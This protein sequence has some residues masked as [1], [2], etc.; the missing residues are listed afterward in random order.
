MTKKQSTGPQF[1]QFT[2]AASLINKHCVNN[3]GL[4]E[5]HATDS[6][7][8]DA[9][10]YISFHKPT[11]IIVSRH[12]PGYRI[13]DLSGVG[14]DEALGLLLSTALDSEQALEEFRV[15]LSSPS[16]STSII[17]ALLPRAGTIVRRG[18]YLISERQV[19]EATERVLA[20]TASS[21]NANVVTAIA[22]VHI[23]VLDAMGVVLMGPERKHSVKADS[24]ALN[25]SHIKDV[26]LKESLRDVFSEARIA[27]AIRKLTNEST[28]AIIAEVISQMLRQAAHAIPEIR[29]R[30]EQLDIVQSLIQTYYSTPEK[31]SNTMRASSALLSLAGYANFLA[32]VVVNKKVK[33]PSSSNSDMKEACSSILTLIQAAPSIE[34]MSLSKYAEFVGFVPCSSSEGIYRG[35]VG[36]M[37]L[38]QTSVLDLVNES[39]IGSHGSESELALLPREYVPCTALAGDISVHLTSTDSF[40]GLANIVAD[41]ISNSKWSLEDA[42][43]LRTIGLDEYTLVYLAM[44][45]AEVTAVV[46]SDSKTAP[47][48]LIYATTVKEHWRTRLAASTPNIAYFGDA[49]SIIIYQMGANTVLPTPLPTRRQS[50]ELSAAY[51]TRYQGVVNKFLSREIEKPYSFALTVQLPGDKKETAELKPRFVPLEMLVGSNPSLQRG[52]AHYALVTEPG[53][54]RDTHITLGLAAAYASEGDKIMQDKAKSWLVESLTPLATHPA[55]TRIAVKALNKAVI[56]E[57]LD[58][59]KLAMT[60]KNVVVNAYFATAMGLLHR[61][62]KV[63]DDIKELIVEHMPI[64]TLEVKAAITLATIPTA[65][66][67]SSLADD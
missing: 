8:L 27:D 31:L 62:D 36:Y 6:M 1:N 46:K 10:E 49:Q 33:I 58:A 60:Y 7:L 11:E 24:M 14:S 44:A 20:Q 17:T 61:F 35:V 12:F 29:L 52:G 50:L 53:V 21:V 66:D 18:K 39:P 57:K 15:I 25:M 48:R 42:P 67:A 41:E 26:I 3:D 56:D 45:K 28:P 9:S 22:A 55:V 51:D 54:N 16:Y 65:V 37:P 40:E 32:D 64:S 5:F 23:K 34:I 63:D 4:K 43:V 2:K 19:T 47:F 13:Y 30:L 59:R 38:A